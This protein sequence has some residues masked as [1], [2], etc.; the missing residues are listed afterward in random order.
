MKK[1]FAIAEL[2]INKGAILDGRLM[3]KTLKI[4]VDRKVAQGVEMLLSLYSYAAVFDYTRRNA[5]VM[6]ACAHYYLVST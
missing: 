2:L 1:N 4:L 6:E 3:D 5:V